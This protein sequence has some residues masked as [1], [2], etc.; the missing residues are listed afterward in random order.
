MTGPLVTAE[1]TSALMDDTANP[2]GDFSFRSPPAF[3][4]P[5]EKAFDRL[6]ESL[7]ASIGKRLSRLLRGDWGHGSR[8]L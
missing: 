3:V 1:E 7:A 5:R 6:S 8:G 4:G 2:A